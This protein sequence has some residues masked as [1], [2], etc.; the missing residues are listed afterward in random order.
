MCFF[1]C[2]FNCLNSNSHTQPK[3]LTKH[4]ILSQKATSTR[5]SLPNPL[6]CLSV[7]SLQLLGKV[8]LIVCRIEKAVY[9]PQKYL[10]GSM[11][12]KTRFCVTINL[13][14]VY[15]HVFFHNPWER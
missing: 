10:N 15:N 4:A 11:L 14:V 3:T 12:E 9:V 6:A 13:Q 2:P 8:R 7:S 1:T 5:I